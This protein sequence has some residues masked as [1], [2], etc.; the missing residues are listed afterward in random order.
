MEGQEVIFLAA[1]LYMFGGTCLD[2][3]DFVVGNV[4]LLNGVGVPGTM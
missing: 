4:T 3:G 1:T 2:T